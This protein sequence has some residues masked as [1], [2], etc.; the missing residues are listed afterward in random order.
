MKWFVKINYKYNKEIVNVY[1]A[2]IGSV[3]KDWV[4]GSNHVHTDEDYE[5]YKKRKEVILKSFANGYS[6]RSDV[7]FNEAIDIVSGNAKAK[8]R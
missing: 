8:S 4:I 1:N 2:F 5:T 3:N 6:S 7:D